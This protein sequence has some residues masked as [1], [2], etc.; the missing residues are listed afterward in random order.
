[1]N[2]KKLKQLILSVIV[3]CSVLFTGMTGKSHVNIQAFKLEPTAIE[4]VQQQQSILIYHSHGGSE[5]YIEGSVIEA[6]EKLAELL[7]QQ[8][9]YVEHIKTEFDKPNYNKAYGNSRI[10]V[11]KK[12]MERDWAMSIDI[13]RDAGEKAFATKVDGKPYAKTMMV[14]TNQNK[15]FESCKEV[16]DYIDSTLDEISPNIT[17]DQLT[18]WKVAQKYFNQDLN[19]HS[20]LIEVGNDKC[21]SEA[22]HNTIELL[23]NAITKYLHK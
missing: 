14:L 9:F 3:A 20:L 19:S 17:R 6:G 21:S 12:M 11:Q 23:S 16:A 22:V 1:M 5:K 18:K 8:G 15:Y 13:H 10:M 4:Y 7:R 2:R